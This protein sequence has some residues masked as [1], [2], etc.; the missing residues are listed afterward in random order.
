VL[1]D[2]CRVII[3]GVMGHVVLPSG[4]MQTSPDALERKSNWTIVV[5]T[6]APFVPVTVTL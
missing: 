3:G 5:C 4:A 6:N 1:E 2:V